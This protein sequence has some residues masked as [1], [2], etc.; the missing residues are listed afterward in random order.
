MKSKSKLKQ[1]VSREF[2]AEGLEGLKTFKEI[3][4]QDVDAY[5]TNPCYNCNN[6]GLCNSYPSIPWTSI[7]YCDVCNC[8]NLIIY[9]DRM[10]TQAPNPDVVIIYSE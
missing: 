9:A 6:R 7:Y 1:F 4:K 8:A 2:Q 10:G 3:S 5:R